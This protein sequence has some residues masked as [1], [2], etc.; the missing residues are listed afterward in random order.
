M[1][2]NPALS[3]I[4]KG[5]KSTKTGKDEACGQIPSHPAGKRPDGGN[6]GA[7]PSPLKSS[8]R[9]LRVLREALPSSFIPHPSS[10]SSA[11]SLIELLVVIVIF[12]IMAVLAVPA[13]N[14][15]RG[16]GEVTRGGQV[17]ADQIA[18]ARQEAAAKNRDI[19]VRIVE[20]GGSDPGYRGVQLWMRGETATNQVGRIE[21]MPD[22]VLISSNPTLSPLLNASTT[23]SGN[24]NFGS[25]GNRPYKGFRIRAGGTLDSQ[26]TTSNNF[27]TIQSANVSNSLPAN[28]FA[29]RVNPVTGRV[30]THRP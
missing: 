27:L 17:L 28:F 6:S 9:V 4:K 19:E 12:S 21:T 1:K 30:T 13:F 7:T 16:A 5:T 2:R 25:L 14:S 18:L 23:V 3:Y 11:F 29:V 24:A 8:L 10:F 15:V 20:V 22:R 26:I